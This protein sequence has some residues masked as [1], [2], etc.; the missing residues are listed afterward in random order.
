MLFKGFIKSSN[1][2]LQLT[3]EELEVFSPWNGKPVP[4]GK[5]L[6]PR[7]GILGGFNFVHM[8]FKT[9]DLGVGQ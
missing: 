4:L 8:G 3:G 7:G 2:L 6:F 1:P 5:C 9:V